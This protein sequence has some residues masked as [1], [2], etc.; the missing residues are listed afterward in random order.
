MQQ[1]HD[2]ILDKSLEEII[3]QPPLTSRGVV[4]TQTDDINIEKIPNSS[5]IFDFL[6]LTIFKKN[7]DKFLSFFQVSLLD[8]NVVYSGLYGYKYH[9]LI[10]DKI[11]IYVEHPTNDNFMIYLS[12]RGCRELIKYFNFREFWDLVR[13][14]EYIDDNG[15]VFRE[16]NISRLDIAID[17]FNLEYDL[18]KKVIRETK[19]GNLSSKFKSA[20]IVD[21]IYLNDNIQ[22]G[23]S[24]RFG[25]RSSNVSII[26]YNKLLERDF[27]GYDVH[28]DIKAW[29]RCEINYSQ[30]CAYTV[31]SKMYDDDFSEYNCQ[32]IYNYLDFKENCKKDTNVTRRNTAKWWLNFINT[33][34]KTRI[35]P[36]NITS[37]LMKKRKWIE[38]QVSKSLLMTSYANGTSSIGELLQSG[39]DKITYKDIDLINDYYADNNYIING[40]LVRKL[41]YDD[42]K[43]IK[44]YVTLI[45]NRRI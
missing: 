22:K 13:S 5:L 21:E 43:S 2:F 29:Y 36:I 14:L 26:F 1:K 10:K 31:F 45:K 19:K 9:Y 41:T 37:N 12:G 23:N 6:V 25:K 11:K 39:L 27:A 40:Q 15:V 4:I 24:V 16:Y 3:G 20:L 42:L 18:I 44:G 30:E 17:L 34:Q 38:Q 33:Y 8:V 32:V 35:A 28:E 7:L